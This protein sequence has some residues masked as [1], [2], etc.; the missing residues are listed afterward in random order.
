MAQESFSKA[1]C[2]LTLKANAQLAESRL[3]RYTCT[4]VSAAFCGMTRAQVIPKNDFAEGYQRDDAAGGGDRGNLGRANCNDCHRLAQLPTAQP[5]KLE[6]R[7]AR[8]HQH[9][10]HR[11][12]RNSVGMNCDA[13]QQ[14]CIDEQGHRSPRPGEASALGLHT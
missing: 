3:A 13:Q 1:V 14:K 8:K 10:R 6:Q 4:P 11:A 12:Q 5:G 9:S 2:G 7:E